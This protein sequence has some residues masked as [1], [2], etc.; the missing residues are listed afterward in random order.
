V[1]LDHQRRV[2]LLPLAL[3]VASLRFLVARLMVR[4]L[5]LLSEQS[6][7]RALVLWMMTWHDMILTLAWLQGWHD[8]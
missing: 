7:Q 5:L 3:L 8:R 1:L 6:G 4:L 2:F